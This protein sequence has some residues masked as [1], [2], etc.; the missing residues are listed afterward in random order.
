M[1]LNNLVKT[2]DK[3]AKRLGRGL[4]SGKGKTAGRGTKGQKS[5]S[6]H[7]IPRRMEG[8]QTSMIQRLPKV[9]GF[10]SRFEKPLVLQL[11]KIEEK[12]NEGE[13]VSIKT[14]IEK[15]MLKNDKSKVKVIGAKTFTKKLKF[16]DV[17]F[18]KT[19]AEAFKAQTE[20][21]ATEVTEKPAKADKKAVKAPKKAIKK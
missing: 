12:F 11:L 15:G 20:S 7:N 14:L 9:R 18:T 4:A 6:G 13:T 5:R 19:L 2:V 8:G 21:V 17:I 1:Q 16:R 3:S 10:N